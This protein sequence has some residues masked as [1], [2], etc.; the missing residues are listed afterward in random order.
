MKRYS[1][2]IILA[3]ILMAVSGLVYLIHYLIFRDPEHI[4]IYMIG[5][6]AFLPLEVLLVVIVI[7]RILAH[8]EKLA[9]RQKL[10]MVVGAFFSEQ[11]NRLLGNLLNSFENRDEIC[12][13]LAVSQ[14]WTASDFKKAKTYSLAIEGRVDLDKIDLDGLKRFLIQER[15]FLLRLLENPNLLEQEQFSDL[16]WATS[17]L[18]EELEAR[19]SLKNLP[20]SDLEHLSNDTKRMYSHLAAEW[21]SYVEHLKSNYP[22]LFSLVLRTHPFQ[23]S[24]SAVVR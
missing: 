8:R 5:D 16:L 15:P 3:A 19:P 2:Y 23:E 24:P 6:L 12:Q 9:I 1:I 13:H 18:V 10:N 21:V 22:Y 14:N 7:E 20:K 4:F 17:H 11:G